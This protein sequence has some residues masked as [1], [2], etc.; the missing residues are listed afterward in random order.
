MCTGLL[1]SSTALGYGFL[2]Q[3]IDIVSIY[4]RKGFALKYH[5]IGTD[6]TFLNRYALF[7]SA[8]C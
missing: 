1:D 5:L 8:I 7:T 6:K 4:L 2:L 3:F